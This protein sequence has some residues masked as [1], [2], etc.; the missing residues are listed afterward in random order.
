[1]SVILFLKSTISCIYLDHEFI[2]SSL[3][4]VFM[5]RADLRFL[6]GSIQSLSLYYF[7]TRYQNCPSFMIWHFSI[8]IDVSVSYVH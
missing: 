5:V 4:D 3:Y 6:G 2:F 8:V 1:M 7:S